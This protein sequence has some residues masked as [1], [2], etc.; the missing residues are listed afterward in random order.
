MA[1]G[2]ASFTMEGAAARAQTGK[3]VLYRRWPNRAQLALAAIRRNLGASPL[4]GEA[5][6]TGSLRED[7]LYV[8]RAAR[9]RGEDIPPDLIY[10]LLA[11]VQDL[12]PQIFDV[13]PGMMTTILSH[14]AERGEIPSAEVPRL[15]TTLPAALLRHELLFTGRRI[16]DDLLAQI[17]DDV[18]LPLVQGPARSRAR[19]RTTRT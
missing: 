7:T 17:V 18:F 6:D 10:G 14:A 2:Y 11:D 9:R 5:P 4:A 19:T 13:I 3:A 1:V 16:S 8:L 12:P 15:V